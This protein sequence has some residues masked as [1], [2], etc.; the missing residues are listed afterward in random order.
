[1]HFLY[2]AD[3]LQPRLP[4]EMFR[5][6]AERMA[7]D[8]HCVS[9]MDSNTFALVRAGGYPPPQAGARVVY[10][11]WMLTPT[12]YGMLADA[13]ARQGSAMVASEAQYVAM[14]YLP[15]WYPLLADLTPETVVLNPDAAD[16]VARLEDLQ[17][18]GW[19]HFFV[20]DYV[21]SLKTSVGS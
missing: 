17:R 16:L 11:G 19:S 13:V 5:A 20:K 10:R 18:R 14:H 3:L 21:K 12:E 1:M 15:N 6:E 7:A 9:L 4:D 8:G 2:P